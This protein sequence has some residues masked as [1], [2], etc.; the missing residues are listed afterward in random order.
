MDGNLIL[1]YIASKQWSK[2]L[3][4]LK[5]NVN[6]NKLLDDPNFM[7]VFNKYFVDEL[8]K[9]NDH[10][11]EDYQ[12][13]LVAIHTFHKSSSY[14]FVLLEEEYKKVVLKLVSITKNVNFAFIYPDEEQCKKLIDAHNSSLDK[15]IEA[16]EVEYKLNQKFKIIEHKPVTTDSIAISIFKSPQEKDVY[17]AALEVFGDSMLL[18]NTALSTV[19]NN[20][21]IDTLNNKEKWFF[22]STTVDLVVIS[23]DTD[24][25]THF[26][27]IDSS[28]HDSEEQKLKDALK[29]R[30]ITEAGF[31]LIRIRQKNN[32]ASIEDYKIFLNREAVKKIAD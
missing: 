19:I 12:M 24:L 27:E 10:E 13:I 18:P 16:T 31:K 28:F 7:M 21:V 6:F 30:L 11:N 15:Q 2:L 26:I 5:D 9:S 23:R 3:E 8:L 17:T 14:S 22:L 32:N 25:P 29:N 4:S 1:G 20:N